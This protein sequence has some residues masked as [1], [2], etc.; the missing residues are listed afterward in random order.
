MALL[1][2]SWQTETA[3]VKNTV[4]LLISTFSYNLVFIAFLYVLLS[5][6]KLLAGYTLDDMLVLTFVGQIVYY[7]A[8]AFFMESVSAF[9][10]YVKSG[11]FDMLI[12][13]P[14]SLLFQSLTL[15]MRPFSGL[16]F[17]LPPL[18]VYAYLIIAR[19]VF[20]PS[21]SELILGI[22]SLV[23][24]FLFFAIYHFTYGMFVFRITQAQNILKII[25]S[26]SDIG[27]YPFE[28]YEGAIRAVF[29]VFIPL[30]VAGG[31]PTS[32]FLGKTVGLELIGL[33]VLLTSVYGFVFYYLWKTGTR[34]YE[35]IS[36]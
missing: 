20:Q 32:Y 11:S 23:I 14:M 24:G 2:F 36:S 10:K 19:G 8:A 18:S 13:R 1:R 28:A 17:S 3:Y 27:A 26:F 21:L 6:I 9:T 4:A 31:I 7:A 34:R 15:A 12:L 35:S 29:A 5:K 25:S 16:F 22:V 33:Q 30:L